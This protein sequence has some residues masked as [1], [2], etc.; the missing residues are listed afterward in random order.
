MASVIINSN[1]SIIV[2]GK[3]TFIISMDG[4]CNASWDAKNE[5]CSTSISRNSSKYQISGF[6]TPET[7]E[8]VSIRSKFEAA[9]IY[10][11]GSPYYP[12]LEGAGHWMTQEDYNSPHF[13]GTLS[14]DEPDFNNITHTRMMEYYNGIKN[15]DPNHPV[16]VNI[17]G[18]VTATSPSSLK[19]WQ[20]T[21]DIS[22]W[23]G[24]TFFA[25][26]NSTTGQL[27]YTREQAIFAWEFDSF[28]HDMW[29]I[30][31][32]LNNLKNPTI[33][34]IQ[35]SGRE[36]YGWYLLTPI[37]IRL[38]TFTAITIDVKGVVFWGYKAWGDATDQMGLVV[39]PP[40]FEDYNNQVKELQSL[41][42]IL[43]LPTESF[44]WD[45]Y[46]SNNIVS[47]TGSYDTTLQPPFGTH[48]NFNWILK[49]DT[50]T[51]NKYLIAINK[52]TR[53]LTST[54]TIS[55][56]NNATAT[57]IGNLGIGSAKSGRSIQLINN[58]FTDIFDAQT[59]N[60]YKLT[61]TSNCPPLQCNLVF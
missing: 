57:T 15:A 36:S 44:R 9:G 4:I 2:D 11:V 22:M 16:I 13:L 35:A 53:S 41:H 59:V 30:G 56:L 31:G 50:T 51:G 27:Y 25:Y 8:W 19:Y 42:D 58:K 60:I 7:P 26:K 39:N 45:G 37:E 61:S 34:V 12:G 17:M 21:C 32:N 3:I 24:Y 14:W 52:G 18:K 6:G 38:L 33:T 55:S 5:P 47:L 23:D 54:I 28:R 48:S 20:D 29:D 46:Q 40:L 10:W 49:N 43:T 1:R